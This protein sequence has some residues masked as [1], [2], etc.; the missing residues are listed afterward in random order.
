MRVLFV[1]DVVGG[2]GRAVLRS[3]LGALVPEL[4]PDVVIVNGENAAG[5]NG[6][7]PA[8]V[9]D[10]LRAG[11]DVIT[12]GNHV[13]DRMEIAPVLD[14]NPRVLRPANYPAPAAGSG[15][16]V[17][18]ARDGSQVAVLNLM[19]RVFLPS[20]E[21]PFRAADVLLQ[22]PA[23]HADAVIVDFHAEATSE[24]IAMGWYLDGRV[25]AVIGTHTHVTTADERVLPGGTAY[26]TDVGMTGPHD[27]VIGVDKSRVLERFLTQRPI[28]YVTAEGDVR[29]SGVVVEVD[30]KSRRAISIRRLVWSARG[31]DRA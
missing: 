10:I 30:V 24:K 19:G 28:R 17:I 23:R 31:G 18:E 7:T 22:G 2:P 5:G 8:T 25:A 21:D 9:D 15:S 6:M 20:L 1:G 11:A 27:S 29:L 13:W 26:I 12:S 4:A 14:S 3:A 16:V